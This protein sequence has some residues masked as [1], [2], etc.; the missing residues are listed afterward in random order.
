MGLPG[1]SGDNGPPWTRDTYIWAES[2]E[3]GSDRVLKLAQRPYGR[4]LVP[5]AESMETFCWQR[6]SNLNVTLYFTLSEITEL[7]SFCL[8]GS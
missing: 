5:L 7:R 3:C 4:L 2:E 1:L 8:G 6:S